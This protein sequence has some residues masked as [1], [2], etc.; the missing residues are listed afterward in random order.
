MKLGI[1]AFHEHFSQPIGFLCLPIQ[2]SHKD[3]KLRHHLVPHSE[4]KALT[5]I[6]YLP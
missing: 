3:S 6:L 2:H 4:L 5:T 1:E